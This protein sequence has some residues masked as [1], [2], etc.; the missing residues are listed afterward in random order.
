MKIIF[1]V[2]EIQIFELYSQIFEKNK[3]S[4]FYDNDFRRENKLLK[5]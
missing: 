5:N 1:I 2:N 4:I 3:D